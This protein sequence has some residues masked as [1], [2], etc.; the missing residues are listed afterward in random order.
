MKLLTF[1]TAKVDQMKTKQ[2]ENSS[3]FFIAEVGQN[4]NGEMA[5]AKKLIDVAAMPILDYFTGESLPRVNAEL[6]AALPMR[7]GG[8]RARRQSWRYVEHLTCF[9]GLSIESGNLHPVRTT[10][11]SSAQRSGEA[12]PERR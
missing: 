5:L 11:G 6:M 4:H 12:R 2:K 3:V 7:C 1:K 10:R 8:R 9:R